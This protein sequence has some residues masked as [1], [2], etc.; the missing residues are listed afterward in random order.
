[1]L[2]DVCWLTAGGPG[3]LL[4]RVWEPGGAAAGRAR[5]AVVICPPIGAEAQAARRALHV[6][7]ERL[8]DAGFASVSFDW[9]GTGGSGGTS[10]G[11]G[12]VE[13]WRLSLRRVV[14]AV[15]DAGASSVFVVGMR[16]GA[17]LAASVAASCQLDG[18]VLWDPCES[19]RS[20]LKE[21]ALLRLV[22][23]R[24]Q[25]VDEAE[26]GSALAGGEVEVL[27][28]VYGSEAAEAVRAVELAAVPWPM[29]RSV[30]VL[31]RPE[32]PLRRA[33]RERLAR[34]DI[35][36]APASGQESLLSIWPL[37]AEAPEVVIATITAWI[38]A[39]APEEWSSFHLA[40]THGPVEVCE[41][42]SEQI[43]AVGPYRLFGVLA[44]PLAPTARLK[45]ALVTSGRMD[46]SGPGRL[47]TYLSRRWAAQGM[48]VLRADIGGLG[49]SAPR[50]GQ[51]L[52]AA[53]PAN[54]L[55]DTGDLAAALANGEALGLPGPEVP[56]VLMG[57]CSGAWHS[58]AAVAAAKAHAD[59]I[60][61][62]NPFL[63][64][65]RADHKAAAQKAAAALAR[66]GAGTGALA[67]DAPDAGAGRGYS[68]LPGR[69]SA[70]AKAFFSWAKRNL[71]ST[72]V[73]EMLRWVLD[74]KWWAL[75]RLGRRERSVSYLRGAMANGS[76][77]LLACRSYEAYLIMR[78]ERGV[79]RQLARTGRFQM[80]VFPGTDHTLLVRSCRAT[81]VGR[82]EEFL[83]SMFVPPGGQPA[84]P[85]SASRADGG[86][87]HQYFSGEPTQRSTRASPS[88][89]T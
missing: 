55:E 19:G 42:V 46:S 68:V 47:W 49:D 51:P 22:Y 77:V 5:A 79:L 37:L 38:G 14:A 81:V 12:T 71:L 17:T 72:E 76:R 89:T 20:Y 66:A 43:V 86:R 53:F 61:L 64:A 83:G 6:L 59:A 9:A 10:G 45:V 27:G 13:G 44:K 58:L 18:L 62:I 7:G 1:M 85:L 73:K 26:A 32:R 29:A 88:A 78:G 52:D 40:G 60:A 25:G 35:E 2:K 21:E 80:E 28:D 23:L 75:G 11:E 67:A 34:E 74:A 4:V 57:L 15:R 48:A 24:D 54:A 39:K 8:A 63:P 50:P 3:P 36:E 69:L 87:N 84:G 41:G 65:D 16:L 33:V 82:V 31:A 70:S 30:L 56:T